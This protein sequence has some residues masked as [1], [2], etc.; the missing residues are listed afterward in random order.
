MGVHADQPPATG[1]GKSQVERDRDVRKG[2][3]DDLEPRVQCL[4][5][6]DDRAGAVGGPA[7]DDHELEV[8]VALAQHRV[9]RGTDRLLLVAGRH[10]HGDELV[11]VLPRLADTPAR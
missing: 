11:R 8:L 6:L 4:P 5:L 2:V 10:D 9:E 1:R 3:G 7:V